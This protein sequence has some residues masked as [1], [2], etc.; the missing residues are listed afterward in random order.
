MCTQVHTSSNRTF[1]EL[2]Y[3]REY[4]VSS[5]SSGSNRTFMELKFVNTEILCLLLLL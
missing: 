1:M 2:K 4:E 3:D 5:Q